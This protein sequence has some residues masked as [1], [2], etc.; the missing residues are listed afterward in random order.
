MGNMGNKGNPILQYSN[1]HRE[2]VWIFQSNIKII[3][4]KIINQLIKKQI[5]KDIKLCV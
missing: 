4:A 1:D 3:K 5:T 2:S